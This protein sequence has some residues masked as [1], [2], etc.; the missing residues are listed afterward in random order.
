M[1]NAAAAGIALLL[2]AAALAPLALAARRGSLAVPIGATMSVAILAVAFLNTGT[3][4]RGSLASTDV[5]HLLA[6][7]ALR[8]RCQE[9]MNALIDARVVLERPTPA[10]LVV[11]GETWDQVPFQIQEAILVCAG[12]IVSGEPGSE[13]IELIRR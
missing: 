6:A 9:I 3:A 11:Q 13:P 5:T 7:D 2:Y 1:T 8:G 10:G 4:Q 12:E